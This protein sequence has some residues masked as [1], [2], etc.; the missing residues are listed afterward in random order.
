MNIIKPIEP[1]TIEKIARLCHEANKVW[2]EMNGDDTQKHWEEAEQWQRDSAIKG[3]QFVI[4]NPF[5][6]DSAQHDSWMQEKIAQGWVHG[7]VKNP[8]AKTHPC[9]RPFEFLPEFQQ[10][11]DGIFRAIVLAMMIGKQVL[12][13]DLMNVP[14]GVCV[15]DFAEEWMSQGRMIIYKPRILGGNFAKEGKSD[16]SI[17]RSRI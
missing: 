8:E 4:D 13:M 7:E 2:C 17:T 14:P 6:G 10:R 3:V 9:I 1:E 15:A 16:Y 12:V 11:K 5:A